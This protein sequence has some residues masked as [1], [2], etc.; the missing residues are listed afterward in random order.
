MQ[1]QA[2]FDEIADIHKAQAARVTYNG[3]RGVD[4]HPHM[5]LGVGE[6]LPKVRRLA[7]RFDVAF[8]CRD[9]ATGK[10]QRQLHNRLW[11]PLDYA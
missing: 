7:V 4:Y 8:W 1:R 2:V 6:S 3:L 10:R 9:L 5:A 11:R